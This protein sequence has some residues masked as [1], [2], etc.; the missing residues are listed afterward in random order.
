MSVEK[1]NVMITG[2]TRGIGYHLTLGFLNAGF[3]VLAVDHKVHQRLPEEV[4]FFLVD[5]NEPEDIERLF[6][7]IKVPIH[8]LVNNAAVSHFLKPIEEVSLQDWDHIMGVNL[9]AAYLLAQ[10][11]VKANEGES[12]GRIINIASTRYHQNEANWD[13]YGISKGGLVAMTQSLC[14]SLSHTPITVNAISPG[15]ICLEHYGALTKEDHTQHPSGRV[16][17]PE[18]VLKACLYIADEENDFLN[19]SNIII[20]GGMTKKMIYV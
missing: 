15:W 8:V 14:V 13:L 3:Q 9:R 18:D 11:F 5:L 19:G 16:G 1:K 17:R 4:L 2:A 7:Q 20:D 12:Y 6:N 10:Q